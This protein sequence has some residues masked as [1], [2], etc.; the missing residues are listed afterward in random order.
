LSE[1]LS[2]IKT[3]MLGTLGAFDVEHNIQDAHRS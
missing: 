1:P 2:L 3:T